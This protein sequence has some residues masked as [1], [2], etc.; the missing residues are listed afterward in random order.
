VLYKIVYNRWS[1]YIGREDASLEN[2]SRA[3]NV[4]PV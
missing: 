4:S 3:V 2:C 1:W